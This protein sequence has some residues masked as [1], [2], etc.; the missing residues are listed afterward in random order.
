MIR[1]I[2][3]DANSFIMPKRLQLFPSLFIALEI[4]FGAFFHL[5]KKNN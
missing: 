3:F 2:D 1:E 5:D 4:D